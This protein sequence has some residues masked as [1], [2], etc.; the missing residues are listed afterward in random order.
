MDSLY[1]RYSSALLS[2][3]KD[4]NKVNEYK[5]AVKSLL[6][7]FNDNPNVYEFLKSYFESEENKFK[8]VDSLV[9]DYN[10]NS[11]SSFIKILIK[12][13]RIADFRYIASEFIKESNESLGISEGFVYSVNKLTSSQ[14]LMIEESISKKLGTKVELKNKLDPRLIGG[15]KVIVHDHV[16]DGSI[17]YKIETMKNKLSERRNAKWK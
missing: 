13:H 2:L 16:F 12:K 5:V 3:A 1:V 11:L 10:L 14:I 4:E 8:I 9:K 17:N 6:E 15:V 7:F